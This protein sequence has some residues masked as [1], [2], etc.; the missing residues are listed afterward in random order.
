MNTTTPTTDAPA[1]TTEQSAD[2]IVDGYGTFACCGLRM[3]VVAHE[4][5]MRLES[6]PTVAVD[7][8]MAVVRGTGWESLLD[9]VDFA[10][11]ID[12]HQW[13]D[14]EAVRSIGR[15]VGEARWIRMRMALQAASGAIEA[16]LAA[17]R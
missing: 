9:A 12:R 3:P 1:L 8:V 7:L 4:R 13:A 16:G 6:D 14:P 15:Q 2:D 17:H 10:E 11:F 5:A